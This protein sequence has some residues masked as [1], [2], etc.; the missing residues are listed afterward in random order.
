MIFQGS[1]PMFGWPVDLQ[2]SLRAALL[3][4]CLSGFWKINKIISVLHVIKSSQWISLF[5]DRLLFFFLFPFVHT[6]LSSLSHRSE[7]PRCTR[8]YYKNSFYPRTIAQW[9]NPRICESSLEFVRKIRL[10]FIFCFCKNRIREIKMTHPK[11][12]KTI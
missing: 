3:Q 10:I 6:R 1:Q 7:Q 4:P 11:Q 12:N 9:N 8:D 2:T 5:V